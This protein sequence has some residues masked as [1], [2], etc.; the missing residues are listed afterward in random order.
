[1]RRRRLT[2]G[3]IG[4]GVALLGVV[5]LAG[6]QEANREVVPTV[7]TTIRG[8]AG[9]EV[10]AAG[11]VV[12]VG[13]AWSTTVIEQTDDI[14][15]EVERAETSSRWLVVRVSWSGERE[16]S[17][18]PDYTW[19]DAA[20]V[21][22]SPSDRYGFRYQ[23]AQPGEWW[24]EDVLFEVPVASATAGTLRLLPEG[25]NLDLPME[26]GEITV[27]EVVA[28]DELTLLETEPG[29]G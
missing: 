12:E 27:P 22:Y 13:D 16:P 17:A 29:R 7:A 26:I 1:M 10:T 19:R 21:E 14:T 15:D 5:V 23:A 6:L 20:G 25:T 18:V 28:V 11:T 2:P 3:A 9:E 8:T 24:H 4:V